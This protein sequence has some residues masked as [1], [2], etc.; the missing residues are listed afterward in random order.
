MYRE[1]PEW[2]VRLLVHE[3]V[4][5]KPQ[6]RMRLGL[7]PFQ[8]FDWPIDQFSPGLPSVQS[9]CPSRSIERTFQIRF[10]L[11]PPTRKPRRWR[12]RPPMA[13]EARGTSASKW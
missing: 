2:H 4:Y 5:D 11:P 1:R 8:D 3:V 7:V 12:R 13:S 9:G 6:S 10:R